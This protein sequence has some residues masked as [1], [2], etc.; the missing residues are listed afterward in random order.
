MPISNLPELHELVR[1]ILQLTMGHCRGT[2]LHKDN[3]RFHYLLLF[4]PKYLGIK[5]L[6]LHIGKRGSSGI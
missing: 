1:S 4:S 3:I 2:G 6:E 5:S